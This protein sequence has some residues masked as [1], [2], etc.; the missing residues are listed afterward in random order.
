LP[1]A[2]IFEEMRNILV[3]QSVNFKN[4]Y[5]AIGLNFIYLTLAISIFYKSFSSA[6]QKGTLVNIGE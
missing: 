3:N 5:Y 1:L 2:H 6:K 4:I